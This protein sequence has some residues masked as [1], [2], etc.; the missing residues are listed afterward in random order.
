MSDKRR[1]IAV[2]GEMHELGED[3]VEGHRK[4]GREA[5]EQG[6]DIVLAVGDRL[7]KQLALAAGEAGVPTVL[8]CG[9]NNTA[10]KVLKDLVQPDDLVLV[11]GANV[12]RMW[13]IAQDVAGE[14]VS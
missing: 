12:S 11:K 10:T 13:E 14:R 3:A 4:V 2:L 5:G 9:D 1:L 6:I 7:A 8:I